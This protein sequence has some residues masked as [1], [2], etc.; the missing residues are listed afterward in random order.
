MKC[1]KCNAELAGEV[2]FCTRC[3][4]AVSPESKSPES[5]SAKVGEVG[6]V[7]GNLSVS[8]SHDVQNVHIGESGSKTAIV[9]GSLAVLALAVVVAVVALTRP[10]FQAQSPIPTPMATTPA[11]SAPTPAQTP[12]PITLS[13]ATPTS[14]PT[15]PPVVPTRSPAPG[16]ALVVVT[17]SPTPADRRGR[18]LNLAQLRRSADRK[19]V[20]VVAFEANTDDQ[21]RD[22]LT[23][24]LTAI[25]Q[26]KGLRAATNALRP[27]F[28]SDGLFETVWQGDTSLF[29]PLGPNGL[30]DCLVLVKAVTG[31]ASRTSFGKTLSVRANA[32]IMIFGKGGVPGGL[33]EYSEAGSGFDAMGARNA[34]LKRLGEAIAVDNRI[35]P[36]K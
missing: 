19:P 31:E 15:P 11:P 20:A 4:A 21:V 26:E 25:L 1:P 28:Y 18:Y 13:V 14:G 36:E 9:V 32:R 3:G 12:A 30:C 6:M 24:A 8:D 7:R 2:Q 17:P 10:G 5:A 29:G 16:P 34:A 33:L 27:A 22:S 35:M 23:G